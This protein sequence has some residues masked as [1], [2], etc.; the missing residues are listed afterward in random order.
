MVLI[1]TWHICSI[2]WT[3]SKIQTK[4]WCYSFLLR[5]WAWLLKS[6][7]IG[8]AWIINR[9]S[10]TLTPLQAIEQCLFTQKTCISYCTKISFLSIYS[11]K[12]SLSQV[13][14]NNVLVFLSPKNSSCIIAT[15]RMFNAW[16]VLQ[17]ISIWRV[18]WPCWLNVAIQ[19]DGKDRKQS[20]LWGAWRSRR[21]NLPFV[22]VN[23]NH[24]WQ[25]H[26]VVYPPSG[27]S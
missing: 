17:E 13:R 5:K 8:S 14:H 4:T 26:W 15:N 3:I 9:N 21:H 10:H 24:F 20:I 1:H 22:V 18:M 2:L 16:K 7:D 25:V 12:N 19:P 27:L 6:G 11:R 23:S